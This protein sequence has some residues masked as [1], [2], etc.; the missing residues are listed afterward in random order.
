MAGCTLATWSNWTKTVGWASLSL[1]PLAVGGRAGS[2]E[3]AFGAPPIG[4]NSHNAGSAFEAGAGRHG[5]CGLR[6]KSEAF[7]E[8]GRHEGDNLTAEAKAVYEAILENGPLDTVRLRRE[9]RMSA[10]SAKSRSDG[11]W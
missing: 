7:Y 2:D 3:V 11:R 4:G 6:G 5:P 8:L 10:E 9:A 1:W